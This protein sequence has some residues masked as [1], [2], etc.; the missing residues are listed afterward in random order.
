MDLFLIKSQGHGGHAN[1]CMT[2]T[3]TTTH[4]EYKMFGGSGNFWRETWRQSRLAS[5]SNPI[6]KPATS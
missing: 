4:E 5:S 2:S 6:W 1:M 3:N